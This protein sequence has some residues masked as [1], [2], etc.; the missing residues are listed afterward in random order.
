MGTI[1]K[2]ES[3][4]RTN[5]MM[6]EQTSRKHEEQQTNR[7]RTSVTLIQFL[8]HFDVILHASVQYYTLSVC[9][10]VL[11]SLSMNHPLRTNLQVF[12]RISRLG[13]RDINNFMNTFERLIHPKNLFVIIPSGILAYWMMS[14]YVPSFFKKV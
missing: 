5:I 14:S 6:S 4:V 10:F 12:N 3:A 7:V 1:G 2:K 9:I 11:E 8:S 13:L